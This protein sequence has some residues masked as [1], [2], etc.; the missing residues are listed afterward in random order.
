MPTTARHR[1][2]LPGEELLMH[3]GY[4]PG[5]DSGYEKPEGGYRFEQPECP[6]LT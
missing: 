3:Y 6:V 2:L 1:V 4:E 5:S